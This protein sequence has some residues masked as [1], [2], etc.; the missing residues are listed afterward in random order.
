MG[1]VDGICRGGPLWPPSDL[2]LITS[3]ISNI[4]K[5]R[6]G[7]VGTRRAVSVSQINWIVSFFLECDV[8]SLKIIVF[9][10]LLRTQYPFG[11]GTPCPY[12]ITFDYLKHIDAIEIKSP[13]A[14]PPCG[15]PK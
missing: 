6:K 7:F 5:C 11:H 3:L 8:K 1:F 2:I 13:G 15:R 10:I 14:P 9:T 12:E 4:S